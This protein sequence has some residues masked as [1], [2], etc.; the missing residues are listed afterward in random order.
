MKNIDIAK[1]NYSKGLWSDEMLEALE[2]KGKIT[3]AEKESMK[4]QV[5]MEK[6]ANKPNK[7]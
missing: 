3:K 5:A 4:A 7:K 6:A 1:K 2:A